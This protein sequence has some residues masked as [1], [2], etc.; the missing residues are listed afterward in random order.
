MTHWYTSKHSWINESCVPTMSILNLNP[1]FKRC[2]SYDIYCG[3][4]LLE[5][6]AIFTYLGCGYMCAI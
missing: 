2:N 6:P 4:I 1:G 5:V 3:Q